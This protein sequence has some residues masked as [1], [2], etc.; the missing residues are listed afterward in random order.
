MYHKTTNF[1]TS[2]AKQQGYRLP[3]CCKTKLF[4]AKQKGLASTYVF[5]I[6]G[7][8]FWILLVSKCPLRASHDWLNTDDMHVTQNKQS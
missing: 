3:F 4:A 8:K 2:A 7:P 5:I 6:S 1:S